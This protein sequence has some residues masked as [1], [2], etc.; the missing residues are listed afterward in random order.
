VSI[1]FRFLC[2]PSIMNSYARRDN[3]TWSMLHPVQEKTFT[4]D[5]PNLSILE[6]S[7]CDE[8][9]AMYQRCAARALDPRAQ[10][11]TY[12]EDL[13]EC[14]LG[15]KQKKVLGQYEFATNSFTI[16]EKNDFRN[17]WHETYF[18]G[19]LLETVAEIQKRDSP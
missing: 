5:F 18:R 2:V 16:N 12:Q 9:V 13:K 19:S 10:C 7:V 11:D 1:F 8:Y 4:Q 14:V 3:S 6:P 17:K 15:T